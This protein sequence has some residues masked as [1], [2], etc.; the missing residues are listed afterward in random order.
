MIVQNIRTQISLTEISGHDN[1]HVK[2]NQAES[3]ALSDFGLYIQYIGSFHR[4]MILGRSSPF[5]TSCSC[6]RLKFRFLM[7][8]GLNHVS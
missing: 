7:D 6:S 3:I 2:S 5:N 8:F 1:P 4:E